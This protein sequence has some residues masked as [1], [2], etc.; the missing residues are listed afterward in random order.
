[1]TPDSSIFRKE[2]ESLGVERSS[3]RMSKQKASKV[4]CNDD[5]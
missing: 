5:Y 4:E 1:M 2:L 3:S